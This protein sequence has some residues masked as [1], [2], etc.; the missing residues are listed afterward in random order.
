MARTRP[1]GSGTN[2]A[3]GLEEIPDRPGPR[4]GCE[5]VP[6][7]GTGSGSARLPV[8][9]WWA[10]LMAWPHRA[11]RKMVTAARAIVAPAAVSWW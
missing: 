4:Y 3:D 8:R 5:E 10:A 6:V 11:R 2:S 7:C 1:S 9:R